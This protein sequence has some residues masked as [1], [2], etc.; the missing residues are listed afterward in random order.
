M[1]RF[2]LASYHSVKH[3]WFE[4][5]T[6]FEVYIY[7][8]NP[9]VVFSYTPCPIRQMACPVTNTLGYALNNSSFVVDWVVLISMV[10]NSAEVLC[11][12]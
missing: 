5:V 8:I 4:E 6:D 3:Q 2:D 10:P 9:I 7:P 11:L 12:F 1:F